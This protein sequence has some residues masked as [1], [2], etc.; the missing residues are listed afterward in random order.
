LILVSAGYDA[1]W[2][3]PLA[4]MQLSIGGYWGL[5]E[6]L[7][8]L[9]DENCQ[10]RIVFTLEGGYHLEVL[11]HAI[12]NTIRQLSG[13]DADVSDPLGPCSW[14]ERDGATVLEQVRRAHNLI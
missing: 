12:L 7:L 6:R 3:D 2:N 8:D 10:G 5:V 4:G 1:H 9:A 14:Q 11:A 13:S